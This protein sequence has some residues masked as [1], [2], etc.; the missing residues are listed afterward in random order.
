MEQTQATTA[1]TSTPGALAATAN[2][3][4]PPKPKKAKAAKAAKP[5]KPAKKAKK[6]KTAKK[7]APIGDLKGPAVLRKYAPGYVKGGGKEGEKATKTAGGNTTIDN[8]DKLAAKL[9]GMDIDAVYK[10]AATVL[11]AALEEGEKKTSVADLKAR[12]G[13]LNVGMQRMNLG[14]RMRGALGIS[15]NAK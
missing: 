15:P 1:P 7:P 13:K 2:A 10:E 4:N 6:A 3:A 14:N 12:Y 11:N 5:T 8:G 9:R